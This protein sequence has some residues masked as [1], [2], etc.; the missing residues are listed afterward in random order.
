[1]AH[2]NSGGVELEGAVGIPY[3]LEQYDALT[4]VVGALQAA[5]SSLSV[6]AIVG[7]NEI[8][9]G[10]KQ[11][12][13]AFFDWCGLLQMRLAA[14]E[15]DAQLYLDGNLDDNSDDRKESDT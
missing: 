15:S 12:P 9:P 10:R 14:G 5:Y 3:E 13:G 8:A 1:M 2:E 11:D 7:H 4:S 6:E